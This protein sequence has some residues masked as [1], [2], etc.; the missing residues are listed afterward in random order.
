MVAVTSKKECPPPH[1]LMFMPVGWID[2]VSGVPK[3]QFS[4]LLIGQQCFGYFFRHLPLLAIGWKI[5]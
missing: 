2:N 1:R 5:L 4:L 3:A